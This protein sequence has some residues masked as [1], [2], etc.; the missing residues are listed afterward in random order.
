MGFDILSIRNTEMQC[1]YTTMPEV[2]N[3]QDIYTP[4]QNQVIV[5]HSLRCV[6]ATRDVHWFPSKVH[7]MEDFGWTCN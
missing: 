5:F 1:L 7:L 2:P 4:L 3:I 6:F